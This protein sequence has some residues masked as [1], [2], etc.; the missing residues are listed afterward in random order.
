MFWL[1]I[2]L[3]VLAVPA[4]VAIMS[5]KLMTG[6][7]PLITRPREGA[8]TFRRLPPDIARLLQAHGLSEIDILRY[9]S[10]PFAIYG[11]PPGPPPARHF[12]VMR[13]QEK[14]VS[15]FVTTFAE[16]VSLTTTRGNHAFAFPRPPGAYIQGFTG[17]NLEQL[18]AKHLEGEL[19]LLDQVKIRV[20]PGRSGPVDHVARVE[21]ALRRQGAHIKSVP[22][23][24]LKAVYWM[25]WTR[26]RMT[27]KSVARQGITAA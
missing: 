27:N 20:A 19:F 23:Y 16:D 17:L 26:F 10:I 2:L 12:V 22:L 9:G 6:P 4:G 24:W 21:R 7:K 11:E 1:F 14:F 5:V 8:L 25:Y 3:L 13:T 15:E 18:W